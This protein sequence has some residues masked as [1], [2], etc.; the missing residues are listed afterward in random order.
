M[1]KR[2]KEIC[3]CCGSNLGYWST[4]SPGVVNAL[5]KFARGVGEKNKN[6]IHLLHDLKD[7]NELSKHEWNN[8]THL[9][10]HGLVAKVCINNVRKLGYWLLTRRGGQF[11][12]GTLSIPK[13]VLVNKNSVI[14]YDDSVKVHISDFYQK[15]PWFET[16]F[17][18]EIVDGDIIMESNKQGQLI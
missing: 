3:K 7:K 10:L 2:T 1:G 12:K 15:Y 4:L 18:Y 16:H 8:F 5:W 6:E 11:L 14:R 17:N 9:R 13:A